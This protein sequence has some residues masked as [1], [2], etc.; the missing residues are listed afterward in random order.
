MYIVVSP[1]KK[2]NAEPQTLSWGQEPFFKDDVTEL[3]SVIREKSA[4]D[5]EK[6]MHLSGKLGQL[7]HERYQR[8]A[9]PFQQE[10]SSAAIY[11]FAG[12]TYV[13]LQVRD[14]S[15]EDIEFADQHLGILSGLY[16]LLRPSDWMQA[17]RLEMGTKLSS[18]RGKDLYQFWGNKIA[19]R[20]NQFLQAE[21]DC[22]I[23]LASGEYFKSVDQTQLNARIITPVF[24]EIRNGQYK[25]ISFS[26]KRARGMMARY[27]IKNR[28]SDPEKLKEF[29]LDNYRFQAELSAE[30]EWVF[31]R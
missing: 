21:A 8:F 27:A 9:L 12:D 7:N 11:S 22:L 18:S 23:N 20:I 5:L 2:L 25:I 26:A 14:F 16:G 28:L 30:N 4:E 3:L 15:V 24:K 10:N 13:G 1:A 19:K 6:L 17:Y 31:V 29:D